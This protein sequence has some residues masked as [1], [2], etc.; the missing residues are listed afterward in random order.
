MTQ[1]QKPSTK[2]NTPIEA[3][4]EVKVEMK[5]TQ[6]PFAVKREEVVAPVVVKQEEVIAPVVQMAPRPVHKNPEPNKKSEEIQRR[7]VS[8]F[9][10]P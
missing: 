5:E 10:R 6:S 4:V 1:I 2:L 8:R 9:T 3:P 7:N